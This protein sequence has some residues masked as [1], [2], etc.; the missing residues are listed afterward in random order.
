MSKKTVL[1]TSNLYRPNIGGIENSLFFIA[2][3]YIKNN[4][5]VDIVVTDINNTSNEK[6]P[7]YELEKSGVNI[8]R[9]DSSSVIRRV[10]NGIKIYYKLLKKYK[11][12]IVISR[13]HV[14]VVLCYMAGM[15]N[16]K[17]LLAGV[18]FEQNSIK[19]SLVRS[20]KIRQYLSFYI[21]HYLQFIAVRLAYKNFVF[22]K[23]M[24][25]QMKQYLKIESNIELC[26]PGVD[27]KIFNLVS[28]SERRELRE[29]YGFTE[30]DIILLGVG[31]FYPVKGFKYA[32]ESMIDLP[33]NVKLLLVGGGE[34]KVL[35]EKIIK[36]NNLSEQVKIIGPVSN[37]NL[38]YK[39]SDIYVLSSTHET[40]GQTVLEALVSGLPICAF[41]PSLTNILTSTNEI[42]D[43]SNC[44]YA[45]ELS[46]K[47]LAEAILS[48]I[49]KL[50]S[51][52]YDREKISKEAMQK[53]NWSVLI[54]KLS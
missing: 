26:K 46:S 24:L 28:K 19:N 15:R 20:S 33:K 6:L 30:N 17:Y 52:Y 18:N 37:T 49:N 4:Y 27:S 50:N 3:E 47:A 5:H 38:Y 35:Y 22:S 51:N 8:Y 25:K 10:V 29:K 12:D 34:E 7:Y 42:T 14:P 16:I 32:I 9:Y 31:R 23:N 36:E 21:H 13:S 40:L 45:N 48:S 44:T 53:F 39:I 2:Q 1:I 11:Y 41:S 54:E 43:E